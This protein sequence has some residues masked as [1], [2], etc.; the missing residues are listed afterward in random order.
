MQFSAECH[1]A[2]HSH[3]NP[4]QQKERG[5]ETWKLSKGCSWTLC[6]CDCLGKEDTNEQDIT[7]CV[8]CL[9]LKKKFSKGYYTTEKG[10][11]RFVLNWQRRGYKKVCENLDNCS[12]R[13]LRKIRETWVSLAMLPPT[14]SLTCWS[15]GLEER[16][17]KAARGQTL[18][19]RSLITLVCLSWPLGS[20][21]LADFLKYVLW[22][23]TQ[24]CLSD[25][26]V[27][28]NPLSIH[29]VQRCCFCCQSGP[30]VLAGSSGMTWLPFHVWQL[31]WLLVAPFLCHLRV[32]CSQI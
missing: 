15:I 20:C 4:T 8:D 5:K 32:L 13:S 14:V 22:T 28:G 11:K 18:L 3:S 27:A 19:P 2:L 16:S 21:A 24:I 30:M 12:L 25:F 1:F 6:F 23:M 26:R 7:S 29:L 10:G 31:S 17:R 9:C